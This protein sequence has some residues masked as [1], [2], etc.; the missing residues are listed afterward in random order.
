MLRFFLLLFLFIYS[1]TSD[2]LN[3]LATNDDITSYSSTHGQYWF[4]IPAMQVNDLIIDSKNVGN[5]VEY[6][7]ID[8]EW[9]GLREDG[10]IWFDG[11]ALGDLHHIMFQDNVSG[12]WTIQTCTF[13][14]IPGTQVRVVPASTTP[15]VAFRFTI[16]GLKNVKVLGS[17][18]TYPGFNTWA[19]DRKFATGYFGFYL[20]AGVFVD[21]GHGMEVNIFENGGTIEVEG[22]ETFM[23]FAGFRVNNASSTLTIQSLKFYN[24]YLHDARTG[25]GIYVGRAA[26]NPHPRLMGIN[27]YNVVVARAACEPF[28]F[29]DQSGGSSIT[30]VIAIAADMD[31]MNA[32]QGNQDTGLQWIVAKSNKRDGY[33]RF[34]NS[35]IDGVWATALMRFGSDQ[36]DGF[37]EGSWSEV[38]NVLV[39]DWSNV[40]LYHH[41]S[42]TYGLEWLFKNVFFIDYN[43]IYRDRTDPAG[44][45][46]AKP[47]YIVSSKLGTDNVTFT[48]LTHDG[49]Q[50]TVFQ[51]TTGLTISGTTLDASLPAPDYVNSGAHEPFHSWSIWTPTMGTY[52]PI[53]TDGNGSGVII[54][55]P[56]ALGDIVTHAEIGVGFRGTFKCIQ[57]HTCNA[58]TQAPHLDATRWVELT[59]DKNGTRSDQP[60]WISGGTQSKIPPDDVRL[61]QGSYW[62]NKG[63]GLT[64]PS[65][66]KRT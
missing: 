36:F 54:Y 18:T 24:A 21:D 51:S 14:P 40:G 60:G 35:I 57:A 48:N 1:F 55:V 11:T 19:S 31:W 30:N 13:R 33:S 50:S 26:S 6:F 4:G 43:G 41:S 66:K 16:S 34:R 62:K 9:P 28:Q 44:V 29:Q 37:I 2:A 15:N 17:S 5:A 56:F 47:N 10:V 45:F 65:P 52:H 22:V 59:W 12:T 27:V 53:D 49:T 64:V 63:M 7:F 8:T 58:S 25:E 42:G 23:G 3:R 39:S 20:S 61:K 46:G 32:F 38:E